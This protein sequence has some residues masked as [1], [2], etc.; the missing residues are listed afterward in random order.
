MSIQR[1]RLQIGARQIRDLQRLVHLL[2]GVLLI[3]F[4]YLPFD[5]GSPVGD[6]VRFVAFPVLVLSGVLMW[7]WPALR[8]FARRRGIRR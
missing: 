3:A 8:R 2:T 5:R 6:G 7:Q 4:V 1:P